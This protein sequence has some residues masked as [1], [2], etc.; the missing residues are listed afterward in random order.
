[1][2]VWVLNDKPLG[3]G[4][5]EQLRIRADKDGRWSACRCFIVAE[6]E[7]TGELNGVIGA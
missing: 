1:M 6:G 4:N 3:L 7:R 2:S 5:R